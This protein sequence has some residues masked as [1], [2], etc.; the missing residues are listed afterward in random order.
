MIDAA[1]PVATVGRW[2]PEQCDGA[3][4]SLALICRTHVASSLR[5]DGV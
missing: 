3:E 5:W 4:T 2:V 1:C